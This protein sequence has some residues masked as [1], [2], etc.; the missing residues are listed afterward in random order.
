MRYAFFDING[1]VIH[2]ET[3]VPIPLMPR[4]LHSLWE[5]GW[6]LKAVTRWGEERARGLLDPDC[7][8][9]RLPAS[10][11]EVLSGDDKAGCIARVLSS[12]GEERAIFLDDKPA[13]I[14][15]VRRLGDSRVE[16][17]G[18]WGSRKYAPDPGS[19]FLPIGVKYALTAIDLAERLRVALSHD[20][21]DLKELRIDELVDLV[22]GLEHPYSAI[23][24]DTGFFDHRMVQAEIF[25]RKDEWRNDAALRKRIWMNLA[26]VRCDECMWKFMVHLA[27]TEGGFDGQEVLGN[28]Y[29]ADEYVAALQ[30]SPAELLRALEGHFFSGLQLMAE[31]IDAIGGKLAGGTGPGYADERERV[32]KNH[33][34]VNKVLAKVLRQGAD[35]PGG[36]A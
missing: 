35:T 17:I 15:A 1:T 24:G 29:Q 5:Q 18:F 8:A 23:A 36:P 12:D 27:L 28:A 16:V 33:G 31:G 22:P 9:A 20:I 2:H 14:E 10:E 3:H 6:H 25:R 34:R 19:R 11:I 13:H 26:W 32:N 4:L 30:A 21:A 7:R